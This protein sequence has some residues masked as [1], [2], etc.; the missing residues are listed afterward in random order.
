MTPTE[1][2]RYYN[3][4]QGDDFLQQSSFV[5]FTADSCETTVSNMAILL[6]PGIPSGSDP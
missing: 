6:E 5:G 1:R 4:Q 3:T 2:R